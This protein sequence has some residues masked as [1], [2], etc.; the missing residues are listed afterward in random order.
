MPNINIPGIDINVNR[1][2]LGFENGV[3][4]VLTLKD[5]FNGNVEDE[6]SINRNKV[7]VP[8][9]KTT[10]ISGFIPGKVIDND[11]DININLPNISLDSNKPNINVIIKGDIPGLNINMKD[12][13][14]LNT[15]KD[16]CSEDINNKIYLNA[17]QPKLWGT[18]DFNLSGYIDGKLP[19]GNIEI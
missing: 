2:N 4:K 15:L 10:S 12:D 1:S 13:F 8:G 3:N 11:N 14:K 18:N 7:I 6:I 16:I 9:Q 19:S 17:K 5:L